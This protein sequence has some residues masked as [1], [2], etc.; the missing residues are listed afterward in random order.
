MGG[1]GGHS[2]VDISAVCLSVFNVNM[3]I[4]LKCAPLCFIYKARPSEKKNIESLSVI[5]HLALTIL[6]AQEAMRS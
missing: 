1:T 2:T 5:H 4:H 6:F 3:T